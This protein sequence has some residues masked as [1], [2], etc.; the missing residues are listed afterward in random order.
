MKILFGFLLI[1]NIIGFLM[2]GIDKKRSQKSQWRV[3]EKRFWILGILGAGIGLYAGM[4][5]YRHKTKHRAFTVGMPFIILLNL[6]VYV[7][8]GLVIN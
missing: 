1:L 5:V 4:K 8:I 6:L 2:M 7:F 3:P